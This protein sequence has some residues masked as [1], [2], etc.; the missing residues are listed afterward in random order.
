MDKNKA[1]NILTNANKI[2]VVRTDRLGDMI[3]TLPMFNVLREVNP[4]ANLTLIAKSYT[5]PLFRGISQIDNYFLTDNK[6]NYEKVIKENHFDVIIFPMMKFEEVYPA[7]RK[8]IKLRIGSGYRLYSFLLNQKIYHHR[9][10]GKKNEAEYNLDLISEI[11]NEKYTPTLI[12][13]NCRKALPQMI[14]DY[15]QNDKYIVIHPGGGGSAPRWSAEN[16]GKLA[17]QISEN[18]NYKI[19]ITGSIS[20]NIDCELVLRFAQGRALN[21]SGKLNLEEIINLLSKTEILISNSTGILHIG[22]A[23]ERKILG[24][25]PNSPAMSAKRW[26]PINKENVILSPKKENN[27]EVDNM[28][29]ITLEAAFEG[30]RNLIEN[31]VQK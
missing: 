22:A 14:F 13:P 18:Y 23:F 6:H 28:S 19:I 11:T 29:T 15:I 10:E 2:A 20:E 16:F 8:N 9:K 31:S 7:F 27:L 21:T 30:F 25:Y 1:L 26:G 3:L 5:E 24:F 17:K 4:K 12:E